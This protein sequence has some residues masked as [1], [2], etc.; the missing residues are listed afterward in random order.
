MANEPLSHGS[1][2]SGIGGFD[3]GFER[4]GI[5]TKW[6]VEV[7]EFC[8][9]VLKRHFPKTEIHGDIDQCFLES[10]L[11]A[12]A[13]PAKTSQ[14]P[15]N[16]PDLPE[17]VPDSGGLWCVPFAWYD[18]STSSWRTWQRS[19]VEGWAPFSE[20]WPR[21][22]MTRNGIA[23]RRA[24]LVHRTSETESSSSVMFPTPVDTTKGGG[25]SRSG[26][27]IDETPSLEGMARKGMW[28]TPTAHDAKN[29]RGQN[30]LFTDGHYYPH[31]LADAVKLFPTPRRED[32]ESCGNHPGVVDSLTGFV[33]MFP[34]PSSADAI[35][36]GH[37][38]R[39]A[40]SPTLA[41]AV[42]FPTPTSSRTG[43]YTVDGKTKTR[44]ASLQGTAKMLPTPKARDWKG[45][46]QRGIH[47]PGDSLANQDR[48]DGTVIGGKLNP[49]WVEWLM[50]FP[51]GWT[52]LAEYPSR[53]ESHKFR[54][55]LRER[56]ASRDLLRSAT[57]SCHK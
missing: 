9:R 21:A 4:A 17:P 32:G 2:F 28:P 33:K 40:S 10:E 16:A 43:D 45:Q 41:S 12:A 7:E 23:Y 15:A 55:E 25:S 11:S 3:L 8:K 24:P 50:N 46:S 57:R 27:R 31:D 34:T 39:G 29:G 47:R 1:L 35:R 14:T 22:G 26:D 6:A 13:S 18:P 19:L 54:D 51:L 56:R 38:G 36:G 37:H 5:V 53:R 52:A 48:G 20:T 30:N 44:R 49:T 42:K